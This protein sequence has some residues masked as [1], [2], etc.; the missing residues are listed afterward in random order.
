MGAVGDGFED[1]DILEGD[2]SS[3]VPF[4]LDFRLKILKEC[5]F[6]CVGDEVHSE[7]GLE[8]P[9]IYGMVNRLLCHCSP[10]LTGGGLVKAFCLGKVQAIEYLLVKTLQ[11]EGNHGR[12]PDFLYPPEDAAILL[13]IVH[14]DIGECLA[15]R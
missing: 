9:S 3:A 14:I 5:M 7:D 2:L 1:F 8:F 6:S 12:Q 13:I 10:K 11:H 4:L 15:V